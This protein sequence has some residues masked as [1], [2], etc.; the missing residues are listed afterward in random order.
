MVR[1]AENI[2][3]FDHGSCIMHRASLNIGGFTLLEILIVML[4]ISIVLT[5][6]SIFLAN[7]LPSRRLEATAREMAAMIRHAKALSQIDGE[8]KVVTIDLDARNYGI[9]GRGSRQIPA[10]VNVKVIDP[11]LGEIGGGKYPIT[12]YAGGGI[13]GGTIVMWSNKRAVN[14]ELDPVMG[15]AVIK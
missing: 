5:I 2:S 11:F 6:A 3:V 8:Q 12:C 4:L 9:A 14:I 15:A 13:N 10:G 7:S 1:E